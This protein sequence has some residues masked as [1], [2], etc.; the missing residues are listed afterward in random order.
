M[1][2]QK[3]L[4]QM[5][6][7][8][9]IED[10]SKPGM[11]F[12]RDVLRDHEQIIKQA[13]AK[14]ESIP[15][16]VLRDYPE[17]GKPMKKERPNLDN[18]VGL[19]PSNNSWRNFLKD[20]ELR[21][22]KNG[23]KHY[24]SSNSH[25]IVLPDGEVITFYGVRGQ[26]AFNA[27]V[28]DREGWLKEREKAEKEVGDIL[29]KSPEPISSPSGKVSNPEDS[30]IRDGVFYD[31]DGE[32]IKVG[33]LIKMNFAG[34]PGD[35]PLPWKLVKAEPKY[36]TVGYR[37][38]PSLTVMAS[39]GTRRTFDFAR[40]YSPRKAEITK[41]LPELL[42]QKEIKEINRKGESKAKKQS[43]AQQHLSQVVW[44]GGFPMRRGNVMSYLEEVA[45]SQDKD[46]WF[47]IREAGMLGNYQYNERHGYPPEG[48]EPISLADFKKIVDKDDSTVLQSI[49]SSRSPLEKVYGLKRLGEIKEKQRQEFV[50]DFKGA[51]LI[52]DR[53]FG[54]VWVRKSD[55]KKFAKLGE[56]PDLEPAATTVTELRSLEQSR[57]PLS[58]SSDERQS[59]SVILEPDDHRVEKWKRDPGS[60]DIRG[61]D[62][63]KGGGKPKVRRKSKKST[64]ATSLRQI[65]SK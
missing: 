41:G 55:G 59:H 7:A 8:D 22:E 33:D 17:L 38:E 60:A 64:Q 37:Y 24:I 43:L 32:P 26:G 19:H 28:E 65:R 23:I 51:T 9:F 4:W 48:T 10:S 13:L 11:G 61:I 3:E 12:N 31:A 45:K 5:T 21:E 58:Q 52:D 2:K 56:Y 14:G 42:T 44:F 35:M 29:H 47:R 6:L 1:A 54:K 36:S 30:G 53:Y 62:T 46:N 49:E 34:H 15:L 27:I 40:N 57:S 39:D 18:I 50:N 20:A 63:P 16:E 25:Y